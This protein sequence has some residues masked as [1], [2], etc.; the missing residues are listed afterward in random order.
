MELNKIVFFFVSN[1]SPKKECF[2]SYVRDKSKS[3]Q[4]FK[5]VFTHGGSTLV[6]MKKQKTLQ[7]L[8]I[9]ENTHDKQTIKEKD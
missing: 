1:E 6:I 9:T 5:D 8:L 3:R 4:Y 2:I 7:L